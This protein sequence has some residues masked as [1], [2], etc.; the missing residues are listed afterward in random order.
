MPTEL[1]RLGGG[2]VSAPGPAHQ[3]PP[4]LHHDS[5]THLPMQPEEP[6][7]PPPSAGDERK[8]LTGPPCPARTPQTGMRCPPTPPAHLAQTPS[9]LLEMQIGIQITPNPALG[10]THPVP[11]GPVVP[12]QLAYLFII[13][14]AP[15]C[16]WLYRVQPS[17]AQ[18][19]SEDCPSLHCLLRRR[20]RGHS[21]ER[22]DR[23]YPAVEAEK[24][25]L[26]LGPIVSLTEADRRRHPGGAHATQPTG[27]R[28]WYALS[29]DLSSQDTLGHSPLSHHS[30]VLTCIPNYTF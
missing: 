24:L 27:P 2:G 21:S 7:T 12:T 3:E 13:S 28:S 11:P 20:A 14:Q 26:F 6:C 25:C 30:S 16:V 8:R 17:S 10:A 23:Y 5:I 15:L 4:L 22:G 1:N 29:L 19:S 9:R 18:T